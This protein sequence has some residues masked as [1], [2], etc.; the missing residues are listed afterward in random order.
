MAID[1]LGRFLRIKRRN[2]FVLMITDWYTKLTKAM[3]MK[4]I[5]AKDVE[6][7]LV[8]QWVANYEPPLWLLSDDGRQFAAK[9]FTHIC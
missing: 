9:V 5:G 1:I 7:A 2:L 6:Q 4:N 3:P 8:K